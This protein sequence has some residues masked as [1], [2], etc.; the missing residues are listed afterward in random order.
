M[1]RFADGSRPGLKGVMRVAGAKALTT[2]YRRMLFMTYQLAGVDIPVYRAHL[3]LG[4]RLL[5]ADDFSAYRALRSDA[6]AHV[7]H[8]RLERGHRC[9]SAWHEGNLIDVC[10]AATESVHVDYLDRTLTLDP[11]DICS[12]DS[13]TAPAFRGRG[14]Y[15][16]RNSWQARDNQAEGFKRAVA[17]VAYENYTAWLILSRCGLKPGATYHYLRFPAKG[18]HWQTA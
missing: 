1:L 7:F 4:F 2:V 5:T 17:L 12:Y 8:S 16:A 13:F 14:V 18:I 10:W 11:G 6:L 9:Y 3:D 15:M